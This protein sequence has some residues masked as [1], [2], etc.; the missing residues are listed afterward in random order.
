MCVFLQS[1]SMLMCFNLLQ[2]EGCFC[3]LQ[4]A[5][6]FFLFLPRFVSLQTNT[7]AYN[8][9]HTH[10]VCSGIDCIIKSV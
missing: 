9:T 5:V 4:T 1:L 8:H 7:L 2:P 10:T 6:F 3:L